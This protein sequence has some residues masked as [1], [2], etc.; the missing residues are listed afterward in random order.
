M[1]FPQKILVRIGQN[2]VLVSKAEGNLNAYD[3]DID[4]YLAS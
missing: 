4:G 2:A 1:S 3:V